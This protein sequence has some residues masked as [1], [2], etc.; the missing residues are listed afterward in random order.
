MI[1]DE[2]CVKTNLQVVNDV[3]KQVAQPSSLTKAIKLG[4]TSTEGTE[5]EG[6]VTGELSHQL[7]QIKIL[8]VILVA[9]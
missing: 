2:S 5:A 7:P 1:F 9:H 3:E 4:D 6:T 8:L